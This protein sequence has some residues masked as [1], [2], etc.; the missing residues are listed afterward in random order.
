[1]LTTRL[2]ARCSRAERARP[3]RDAHADLRIEARLPFEQLGAQSS[4]RRSP[5]VP[6]RGVACPA[7]IESLQST[8]FFFLPP[9]LALL[10][11]DLCHFIVSATMATDGNARCSLV[12]VL[13]CV[14]ASLCLASAAATPA[15]NYSWRLPIPD[16]LQ[17]ETN[18]GYCGGIAE[19]TCIAGLFE[20]KR[21]L[22]YAFVC[23]RFSMPCC[24][25]FSAQR[26][27]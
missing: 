24:V 27:P 10:I 1:M 4:R 12:C 22:M 7:F 16:R 26:S 19:N 17:W 23:R 8:F 21:F 15:Q 25:H 6:W 20:C 11:T 5:A 13:V 3:W 14:M 2:L 9:S 18:G